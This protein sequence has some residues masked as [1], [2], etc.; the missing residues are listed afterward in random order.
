MSLALP[1]WYGGGFE[2][3]EAIVCDLFEWL[4]GPDIPVV[5]WL[6]DDAYDNPR[7]MLRVHRSAGRGDESLPLDNAVVQIGAWSQTRS[8]SWELIGFVRSVMAAITG[9]FKVPRSTFKSNGERIHTQINQVEEWGGPVQV[10]DEF[11]DD[12]LV[13]ANYRVLVRGSRRY[14][15]D[16]Y[17]QI[18]DNLPS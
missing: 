11:I 12:R 7:P 3:V 16:Y 5:T 8:E 15:P 18:L 2:D 10:P 13:T 9:G 14:S 17:R 6:T 1:P 4:L